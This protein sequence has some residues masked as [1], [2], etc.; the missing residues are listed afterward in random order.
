M[1]DFF[2]VNKGLSLK[3][4]TSP[5]DDP[6][7]G[8]IYNDGVELKT[9]NGT[10]WVDLGG[11]GGGSAEWG[12]ITGT[13]SDQTD[14]QEE[15]DSKVNIDEFKESVVNFIPNGYAL[16]G[17]QGISTYGPALV[18]LDDPSNTV[19]L[20]N[21]ALV[22]PNSPVFY[23]TTGTPPSPLVSG[24][25]YFATFPNPGSFSLG[26]TPNTTIAF[27]APIGDQFIAFDKP[28]VTETSPSQFTI[29]TSNIDPISGSV[30]FILQ[31]AAQSAF[32][33]GVKIPFTIDNNNKTKVLNIN[34]DYQLVSGDFISGTSNVSPGELVVW[35]K[36]VDT[37]ELIQPSTIF[38]A[39]SSS[40][41]STTQF[42]STF[43]TSSSG[44][45]YELILHEVGVN[46]SA[47]V[48]RLDNFQVSP[49]VY[50]Y[51]TPI[52][53]WQSYTPVFSGMTIT[54]S[55]IRWRQVA[56]NLEVEGSFVV[57]TAAGTEARISFPASLTSSSAISSVEIAGT[58]VRSTTGA[59]ICFLL[60]EPSVNYF[61]FG[62]QGVSNGSLTKVIGTVL[63]NNGTTWA[64][65]GS[66]PIAGWS[67][68]VQMSDRTDTRVVDFVGYKTSN[69]SVT[70]NVTNLQYT[71][72]K[73]SHNAWTGD[74]Y[75]V[76]VPGDYQIGGLFHSS[77]IAAFEVYINGTVSPRLTTVAAGSENYGFTILPNLSAGDIVSVRATANVTSNANGTKTRFTISRIS[78]PSTIA[79][80]DSINAIYTS[81]SGSTIGTSGSLLS[82]PTRITDSHGSW[83][84][85]LFTAPIP[86]K[87]MVT[88]TVATGAIN[89]ATTGTITLNL[90]KNG[91]FYAAIDRRHGVGVSKAQFIGGS[92]VVTLNAGETLSV[93][94]FSSTVGAMNTG[95]GN[96]FISFVRVGN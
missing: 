81:T 32:G 55:N 85:T 62:V 75:I 95:P 60:R 57:N 59:S 68:S 93:Y 16:N 67:S 35:I 49:S 10:A 64:I 96:N 83:N 76:P 2:K 65:K 25:S 7:V 26:N 82:F 70:A 12:D 37:G 80:S 36:N 38:T 61:T 13:L 33:S 91:A 47:W 24:M 73:D 43:Q 4:Q 74:S 54:S 58:T 19:I 44:V 27:G 40:V 72:V 6:S 92:M 46:T 11:G 29:S 39:V 66:V 1:S 21:S 8:D 86:G 17:T 3:P 15:L 42:S 56:S 53:E 9:W 51:G 23:T 94:G 48:M 34:F 18:T 30:S 14:L 90:Y 45:N 84:G 63:T 89:L 77:G 69:Q 87:Y 22:S 71:T 28:Y 31:K 50:I 41:V 52:T 79:A 20:P 78:G 88:A 5:P